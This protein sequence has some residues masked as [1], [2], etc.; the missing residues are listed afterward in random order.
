MREKIRENIKSAYQEFLSEFSKVADKASIE[1][2]LEH[3]IEDLFSSQKR[4]DWAKRNLKSDFGQAVRL[5][6]SEFNP[7]DPSS[8][9][10]LEKL[11]EA[12][13][14]VF[15]RHVDR[16]SMNYLKL[17]LALSESLDEKPKGFLSEYAS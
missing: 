3:P 8:R 5:Y 16:S 1:E 17:I 4:C 12:N 10:E 6:F 15:E 9:V 13:S 2:R 14:K 11:L 7:M